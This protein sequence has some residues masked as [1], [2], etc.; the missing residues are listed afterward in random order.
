MH[1]FILSSATT[2]SNN[3]KKDQMSKSDVLS[4]KLSNGEQFDY[5]YGEERFGSLLERDLSIVSGTLGLKPLSNET[6]AVAMYVRLLNQGGKS[7]F[8]ILTSELRGE[9]CLVTHFRANGQHMRE[10]TIPVPTDYWDFAVK[11]NV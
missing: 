7:S 4:I 2:Y 3:R 9:T 6:E 5:H 8:T 11:T 10:E 1:T